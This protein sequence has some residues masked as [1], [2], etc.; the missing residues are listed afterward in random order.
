RQLP[1]HADTP[2]LI[3]TGDTAPD[4][5]SYIKTSGIEYLHKPVSTP[6]LLSAIES[7]LNRNTTP[8]TDKLNT[9]PA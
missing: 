6:Q 2:A 9:L 3:V 7:M 8:P 4:V 5:M 1:A